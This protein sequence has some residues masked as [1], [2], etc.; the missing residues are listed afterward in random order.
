MHIKNILFDNENN[1]QMYEQFL[2]EKKRL[3]TMT[4][5]KFINNN[6][7]IGASFCGCY[8][9]IYDINNDT[10]I[11]KY[12]LKLNNKYI[13]VDL[14][15]IDDKYIYCSH[16]SEY[17]IGIYSY[18]NYKINLIKYI[19]TR[20]FGK[21]HGLYVNNNNLYYTTINGL[22][23][24]NNKIIYKCENKQIQS[25]DLFNNNVIITTVSLP[26]TYIKNNF[27]NISSIIFINT[28]DIYE[29]KNK[30]FDG[31]S[32]KDN[33]LYVC[34]QYNSEVIVF[35][36]INDNNKYILEQIDCIKNNEFCHGCHCYD[37]MLAIACYGTNSINLYDIS[38]LSNKNLTVNN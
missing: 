9:C 35:N 30:R 26:A 6:I 17:L 10:M 23:I 14:I 29:Y 3:S 5:V 15:A 16:I 19:S 28:G 11:D 12:Y 27:D 1:S 22:C 21:P 8:L 4:D 18:K 38:Y 7:I 36:I 24:K 34:D 20:M 25:I 13:N 2:N 33:K 31:I 37:N 32:I